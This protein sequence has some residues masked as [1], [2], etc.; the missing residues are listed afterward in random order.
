MHGPPGTVHSPSTQSPELLGPGKG[1]KLTT[2][3]GLCPC[4]ARKNLSGLD[5][6]S[7]QNAGPTWDNALAEHAEA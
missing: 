5:L 7:A 3:L 1:T 2:H 6:E 4:R